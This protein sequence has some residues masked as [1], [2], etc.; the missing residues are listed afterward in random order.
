M[1]EDD[2]S[3]HPTD[4]QLAS[5]Q[6]RNKKPVSF[7]TGVLRFLR[8]KNLCSSQLATLAAQEKAAARDD[9]QARVGRLRDARDTDTIE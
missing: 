9:Q 5:P 6:P 8:T 7:Q 4:V 1:P 3:P 2:E